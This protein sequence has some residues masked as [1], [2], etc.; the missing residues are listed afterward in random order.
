LRLSKPGPTPFPYT[1][2]FR[3]LR[4]APPPDPPVDVEGDGG[5]ARPSAPRPARACPPDFQAAT[6]GL[7]VADRRGGRARAA[8]RR[9][10]A[11]LARSEE[12]TSELQSRGYLVCRL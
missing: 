6:T 12:L 10:P 1:T 5:L 2:L 3:S 4:L 11:W 9:G 7:H 8:A